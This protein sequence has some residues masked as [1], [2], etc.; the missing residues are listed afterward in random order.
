MANKYSY[1]LDDVIDIYL[2]VYDVDP[3]DDID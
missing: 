3:T 1:E 2:L